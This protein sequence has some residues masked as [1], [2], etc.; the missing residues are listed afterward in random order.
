MK[1]IVRISLL[2]GCIFGAV[3]GLTVSLALDFMMNSAPDGG[4]Y[5]SVQHDVA[6][7]LGQEWAVKTWFI[8]FGVVIVIGFITVVGGALGA[9]CG[10][11]IGKFFSFI[12]STS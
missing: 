7:L 4:W 6:L 5:E 12:N 3:L 1:P 10:A 2:S 11:L 9:A 8:Y